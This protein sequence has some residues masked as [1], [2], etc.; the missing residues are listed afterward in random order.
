MSADA[1]IQ[2]KTEAIASAKRNIENAGTS[3]FMPCS[4]NLFSCLFLTFF[5]PFFAADGGNTGYSITK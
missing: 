2:P 4:V 3:S 1:T 5:L